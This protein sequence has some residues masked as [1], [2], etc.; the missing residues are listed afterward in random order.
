MYKT[1]RNEHNQKGYSFLGHP[2]VCSDMTDPN[3]DHDH[4]IGIIMCKNTD[5]NLNKTKYHVQGLVTLKI[6]NI[7]YK[8]KVRYPEHGYHVNSPALLKPYS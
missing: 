2:V 7:H 8:F 3:T 5:L 4:V 6:I 1:L